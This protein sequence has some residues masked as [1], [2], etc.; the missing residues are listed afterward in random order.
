MGYAQRKKQL[1]ESLVKETDDR[2]NDLVSG[3]SVLSENDIDDD[4]K[5]VLAEVIR[6]KKYIQ[7]LSC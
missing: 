3:D 7:E 2:I 1:L 6:Y 4:I 5:D